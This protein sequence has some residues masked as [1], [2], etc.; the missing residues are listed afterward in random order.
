MEDSPELLIVSGPNGSGKTTLAL[1]YALD[2]GWKYVGADAVVAELTLSNIQ[3]SRVFLQRLRSALERRES[4][5]VE[6]TLSGRTFA[7]TLFRGRS[8]GY[9][10]SVVHLFLDSADLCVARVR[11]RVA[12]GGH[13]VPELD[14]RR[15]FSRSALNFWNLYRLMSDSWLL[16]YNGGIDAEVIALGHGESYRVQDRQLFESFLSAGMAHDR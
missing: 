3:A 8:L 1:E 10:V 6:S 11:E 9:S 13:D 5:V 4:L 14:V 2:R 15:R 12:K 7:R 16:M